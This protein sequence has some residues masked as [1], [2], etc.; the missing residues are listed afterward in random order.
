M[1]EV[2]GFPEDFDG[3]LTGARKYAFDGGERLID[4][5]VVQLRNGF[6]GSKSQPEWDTYDSNS[7]DRNGFNIYVGQLNMNET[8]PGEVVP[9]SFFPTW[10]KEVLA[11][12]DEIDGV[13]DNIILDVSL[14]L[15]PSII[16]NP[17]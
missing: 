15:H 3:A 11:Q 9:T 1:R 10:A 13:K 8:T 7:L 14:V 2:Q 16:S 12:C 6:L 4:F 17:P 5:L